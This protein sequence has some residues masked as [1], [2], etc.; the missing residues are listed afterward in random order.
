MRIPGMRGLLLVLL[1]ITGNTAAWQQSQRCSHHTG[2]KVM[3]RL[4]QFLKR[5]G[6]AGA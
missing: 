5:L 2:N 1:G 3:D 4:T 6:Q